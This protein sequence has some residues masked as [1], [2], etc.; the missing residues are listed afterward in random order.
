M[1]TFL[2]INLK[3]YRKHLI[4]RI[5]IYPLSSRVLSQ[6]TF[7]CDESKA[8]QMPPRLTR[9]QWQPPLGCG[10]CSCP[11]LSDLLR[12]HGAHG[13]FHTIR[14]ELQLPFPVSHLQD[15]HVCTRWCWGA[16]CGDRLDVHTGSLAHDPVYT[17]WVKSLHIN[18]CSVIFFLNYSF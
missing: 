12:A 2:I 16:R 11:C 17:W 13:I 4:L 8:V 5:N 10:L 18:H 1:L 15:V 7:S 6:R 9:G 3:S 14:A